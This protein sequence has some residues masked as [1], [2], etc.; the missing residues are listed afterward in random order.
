MERSLRIKLE[1]IYKFPKIFMKNMLRFLKYI[2]P[3]KNLDL[4]KM[5][6]NKWF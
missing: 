2:K 4:T 6:I 1:S 3:T 5:K